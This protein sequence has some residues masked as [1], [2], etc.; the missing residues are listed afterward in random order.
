MNCE[1]WLKV[2]VLSVDDLLQFQN[3]KL[4]FNLNNAINC[5]AG[6]SLAEMMVRNSA[7]LIKGKSII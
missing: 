7:V 6:V 2:K 4:L 1:N 5:L 3:W